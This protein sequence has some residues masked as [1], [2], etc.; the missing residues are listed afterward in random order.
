VHI[1]STEP[2]KSIFVI[3]LLHDVDFV[4]RKQDQSSFAPW[5]EQTL[6]DYCH[7]LRLTTAT[8][9]NP[10]WSTFS[11]AYLFNITGHNHLLIPLLQSGITPS[12]YVDWA[13]WSH[14]MGG[15]I[16][17]SNVPNSLWLRVWHN[18]CL[19]TGDAMLIEV[20]DENRNSNFAHWF[21]NH[22]KL[23]IGTNSGDRSWF[24]SLLYALIGQKRLM[25]KM[26]E[27]IGD[28][29]PLCHILLFLKLSI[30]Y[31]RINTI[32]TV[33]QFVEAL[34]LGHHYTWEGKWS[35][36]TAFALIREI[37][38]RFCDYFG[39][40][41]EMMSWCPHHHKTFDLDILRSDRLSFRSNVE[42]KSGGL[43]AESNHTNRR[44][45]EH[46]C[47]QTIDIKYFRITSDRKHSFVVYFESGM[48]TAMWKS[49][50]KH[51]RTKVGLHKRYV[52]TAIFYEHVSQTWICGYLI[53]NPTFKWVYF[54]AESKITRPLANLTYSHCKY[55]F[56]S[57][58]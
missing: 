44:C 24:I 52:R 46:G 8:T 14:R 10:N 16:N 27:E 41:Y 33:L 43:F 1:R 54:D 5:S 3:N 20:N 56:F 36:D 4:G 53:R 25:K 9:I 7:Q 37:C 57:G 31:Q 26:T 21:A 58:R 15:A 19:K 12:K 51:G 47:N 40:E 13:N 50:K 35:V 6:R 2:H 22:S 29:N 17:V 18:K 49:L 55:V 45:P 32:E 48:P 39:A 23:Q 38:P 30:Q 42:W 11:D 34:L 28:I